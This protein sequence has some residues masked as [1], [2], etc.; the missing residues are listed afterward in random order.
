MSQ[1]Y[2]MVLLLFICYWPKT[3]F[4]WRTQSPMFRRSAHFAYEQHSET[5]QVHDSACLRYVRILQCLFSSEY[6]RGPFRGSF[7]VCIA[8]YFGY[9]HLT[10]AHLVMSVAIILCKARSQVARRVIR[11]RQCDTCIEAQPSKLALENRHNWSPIVVIFRHSLFV[12]NDTSK[13]YK[14]MTKEIIAN[15]RVKRPNK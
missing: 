15:L 1:L 2:K 10:S 8:K 7:F 6:I 5:G 4:Q 14:I 12:G 3:G 13:S 11:T 9:T